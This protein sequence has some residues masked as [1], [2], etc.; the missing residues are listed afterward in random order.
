MRADPIPLIGGF[1]A[2]DTRPWSQQDIVNWLPVSSE[3]QGTRTPT[4]AKTPPGL[5][6]F[7][8]ASNVGLLPAPPVRGLHNAEGK[9]FAAIGQALYQVSASATLT[10]LGTLPGISRVRFAHNQIDGG[11]EVLAV[12]GSSGYVW[13]TATS[14]YTQITDDGYPGTIDVLFMDGYLLQIEPGRRYAFHSDLAD[15]LAYNTLDRFTS[16]VSPDLLVGM[17]IVNNKLLLLSESTGEFFEN[18]GASQQPFRTTR[19]SFQRGCAGRYTVAML[20]DTVLWLG[21]NG[22]FYILENY[23]PKRISTGPI[24]SAIRGLNWAQA[25]AFIWEDSGHLVCYWTFPDGM[26]LGYDL[27][28]GQWHR[29]ASYGLD[30]WRVN[31]TAFWNS[32]W[33]AGDFQRGRLWELDWLY[34]MEGDQ[35]ML[36]ELTGPVMHDNQSRVLMPRLELV[37]DV[38]Q[39]LV[40]IR[41]FTLAITGDLGNG[42][43]GDTESGAYN[44]TGGFAPVTVAV[45][46][47]TFPAGLTLAPDGS[48]SGTRTTPG[49]YNWTVTATDAEGNTAPLN[50]TS[51]TTS[52]E[53]FAWEAI[54]GLTGQNMDSVFIDGN[55]IGVTGNNSLINFS[56]DRG[57]TW[58]SVASP[59]SILGYGIVKFGADWYVFGSF[60]GVKKAIKSAGDTFTTVTDISASIPFVPGNGVEGG[61]NAYIIGSLLYVSEQVSAP[62]NLLLNHCTNPTGTWTPLDTGIAAVGANQ[63]ITSHCESGGFHL[64]GT[65]DGRVLRANAALTSFSVVHTFTTVAAAEVASLDDTVLASNLDGIARSTNNGATFAAAY[66]QGDKVL[67]NGYHFICAGAYKVYTSPTGAS[68]T[69]TERL[70]ANPFGTG[71]RGHGAASES[72][73]CFGTYTTY[74]YVGDIV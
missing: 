34:P 3:S 74:A 57:Q 59:T 37:M 2:D 32:V 19:I 31:N 6:P 33:I 30:R 17:A 50:D 40:E 60:G 69:W 47:G 54:D 41:A 67:A 58:D 26:T 66:V 22:S 72:L 42:R 9:L 1:Y 14:T 48:W 51:T 20:A 21:D 16:E 7:A 65:S 8:E 28:E 13:N 10:S 36:S 55:I 38:G 70:D 46:A 45:T 39:P 44:V 62:A 49:V 35:E 29:R 53:I 12:N 56:L 15:A 68:G 25:F 63:F 4:I 11:N 64:F 43:Q 73:A 27:S 18:T 23:S 52:A 5:S 61:E 24:E 71:V